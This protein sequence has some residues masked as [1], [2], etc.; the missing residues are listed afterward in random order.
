MGPS[1]IRSASSPTLVVSRASSD[2][3]ICSDAGTPG[4]YHVSYLSMPGASGSR[5]AYSSMPSKK[6][7]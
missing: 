6:S 1:V 7:R 3:Q 5:R 4:M 2:I